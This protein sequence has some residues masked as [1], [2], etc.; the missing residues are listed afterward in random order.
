[1]TS[2]LQTQT[3]ASAVTETFDP[4]SDSVLSN[5]IHQFSCFVLPELLQVTNS[6]ETV[7]I[8]WEQR[9]NAYS[10]EYAS[11]VVPVQNQ[12]ID[13][14][15]FDHVPLVSQAA[16]DYLH[17]AMEVAVALQSPTPLRL[18]VSTMYVSLHEDTGII[19]SPTVDVMAEFSN[20]AFTSA[21]LSSS[22]D[23][24]YY[25]LS[26]ED[27]TPFQIECFMV[28]AERDSYVLPHY[29]ATYFTNL[30]ML[31]LDSEEAEFINDFL[32]DFDPEDF[33]EALEFSEDDAFRYIAYH[34][35]MSDV[36]YRYILNEISE[37]GIEISQNLL[38]S[39]VPHTDDLVDGDLFTINGPLED[40]PDYD[41]MEPLPL[42]DS[43]LPSYDDEFHWNDLCDLSDDLFTY[44]S[45]PQRDLSLLLNNWPL[46]AHCLTPKL[47]NEIIQEKKAYKAKQELRKEK[48]ARM[49]EA[50][51]R[52]LDKRLNDYLLTVPM[53][54]DSPNQSQSCHSADTGEFTAQG[55]TDFLSSACLNHKV[56]P[57]TLDVLGRLANSFDKV[58]SFE[59]LSATLQNAKLS[60]KFDTGEVAF[61]T[62]LYFSLL[63]SGFN[64]AFNFNRKWFTLFLI[65]TMVLFWQNGSGEGSYLSEAYNAFRNTI[66]PPQ[67]D[68]EFVAQSDISSSLSLLVKIVLGFVVAKSGIKTNFDSLKNIRE[69]LISTSQIGKSHDG[70][71]SVATWAH[72]IIVKVVNFVRTEILGLSILTWSDSFIPEVTLWCEKVVT[73][74]KEAYSGELKINL[75]GSDRIQSLILEGTKFSAKYFNARQF[76]DVRD[77]INLHMMLLRKLSSV[78]SQAN[79]HG[80]GARTEPLIILLRG[81]TGV[82]KSYASQPLGIDILRRVL[83]PDDMLEMR[84]NM[85]NFFYSRNSEHQYWDGYR[86]QHCVFFDDFGQAATMP[87]NPD[88]EYMNLIRCAGLFQMVLHM[89]GLED[90]GKIV[91]NSKLIICST[92]S[93]HFKPTSIIDHEA[94]NR[95]FDLV[96]D[97]V[98]REEYCRS[99]TLGGD[100]LNRRL[101]RDH[102]DL[103]SRDFTTKIYEFHQKNIL[104][105]TTI[106]ILDWEQLVDIC[107]NKYNNNSQSGD[108]YQSFLK[109]MV[110]EFV[111][112]A[113][114]SNYTDTELDLLSKVS[115]SYKENDLFLDPV[116]SFDPIASES[117]LDALF[118]KFPLKSKLK[119]SLYC[120]DPHGARDIVN[121][122]TSELLDVDVLLNE[123]RVL[124]PTLFDEAFARDEQCFHRY[125]SIVAQSTEAC[126]VLKRARK[127][128]FKFT[129]TNLIDCRTYFE[130]IKAY[131]AHFC[132]YVKN[133]LSQFPFISSLVAF[134]SASAIMLAISCFVSAIIKWFF[135]EGFES[136]G[137]SGEKGRSSKKPQKASRRT[138]RDVRPSNE[139]KSEEFSVTTSF[140]SEGGSDQNAVEIVNKIIQKSMYLLVFPGSSKKAGIVT[141]L[142]GRI[143]IIPYHYVVSAKRFIEDGLYCNDSI[144][145]LQNAYAANNRKISF[146]ISCLLEARQNEC[147][148]DQDLCVFLL[149]KTTHEH[150]NIV[151]YFI[152]HNILSKKLDLNMRLVVPN[153]DSVDGLITVGRREGNTKVRGD[154][155][156]WYVRDT[157]HYVSYTEKGD[158]GALLT[159]IDPSLGAGRI[160]GIHV[161][162][163]ETGVGVSSVVSFEDITDALKLYPKQLNPS[164][165]VLC[166]PQAFLNPSSGDF[167]PLFH[168]NK[169]VFTPPTTLRRSDLYGMW[170]EAKT[171]PAYLHAFL[172]EDEWLDPRSLAISRY[173]KNPQTH[174]V[175]LARVCTQHLLSSILSTSNFSVR[176]KPTLFNFEDAILGIPGNQY[177]NS[178]PRN[179]SAGYPYCLNP[180]PGFPAKTWFFGKDLDYD[181]TRD[182]CLEL[183]TEVTNI[184]RN[185]LEGVR[186][187]HVFVDN[188]KDERRPHAKV[189]QGK[190]RLVS[191]CPLPLLVATRMMFLDFSMFIMENQIHSGSAV[192]INVHGPAWDLLA[193]HL[194]QVGSA[195]IAGDYSGFDTSETRVILEMICDMINDWYNDGPENRRIRETL[196]AEVYNSIHLS[197]RTVY[198]WLACLPSGHPLTTIINTMY[199]LIVMRMAWCYLHPLGVLGLTQ[200]NE[201]VRIIAYGDDNALNISHDCLVFFNQ[202]TISAALAKVGLTYTCEAKSGE[203]ADFRTLDQVSFLKRSFRF[204]KRVH[205]YIAPLELDTIL[206][207]PYWYHHG[208]TNRDTTIQNVETALRELALHSREVYDTHA[209]P[210]V[211][212]SREKLNHYPEIVNYNLLQDIALSCEEM[213]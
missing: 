169:T 15:N 64:C 112:Q 45:H 72:E 39:L 51:K 123:V 132:A 108:K 30:L 204:E 190:T 35:Q 37:I 114:F 62:V 42:Y 129:D 145:T 93:F 29:I 151:K 211:K 5:A 137:P 27:P 175:D 161:A 47:D 34:T 206:E 63:I 65:S 95:R 88:D 78:Y 180:K 174:D 98:P 100:V 19:S 144:L 79:V 149:P 4:R 150:P 121:L 106:Q 49:S 117:S 103:V 118:D 18:P 12:N 36:H 99:E 31:D 213:F 7:S 127:N 120:A 96:L 111:P 130:R 124:N 126:H 191:A 87:G 17:N 32:P 170:G 156:Q 197:G 55:L 13:F 91:F 11:N 148:Q 119:N 22:E 14:M 44:Y 208:V 58:P 8:D 84:K 152:P 59:Q 57:D 67:N 85:S 196:F 21:C 61:Q 128:T 159:L 25:I 16:R 107:V 115:E 173:G 56:D 164:P 68:D 177:C 210:I 199:N 75:S 113:N 134:V 102:P 203:V 86:Q 92:N 77:A 179:T 41:F 172:H 139:F 207:M 43:Q 54:M 182:A 189:L 70:I 186:M 198:Q 50:R 212:A 155:S 20:S 6:L 40:V 2:N 205:S 187:L 147:L 131:F 157:I 73:V 138:A 89:A 53:Q 165:E 188:L 60:V 38:R 105:N 143:A 178:I 46:Q 9:S 1:M 33:I 66:N 136:E 183:K 160:A 200:F 133:Y 185:A 168:I 122:F 48:Q 10:L 94:L 153:F 23:A 158:C 154:F 26:H 146:P 101:N 71:M 24:I 125:L 171:R 116:E 81:K 162:G 83:S 202:N 109:E 167:V 76:S 193:K 140:L 110:D 104:T 194:Q 192:G 97:V 184:L 74:V 195:N 201:K 181:L 69:F 82:G 28:W 80:A 141:V 163:A 142:T 166:E 3:P 176:H 52:N 135:E 209:P 90:K